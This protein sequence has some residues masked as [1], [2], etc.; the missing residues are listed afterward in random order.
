VLSTAKLSLVPSWCMRT[1][2]HSAGLLER[3]PAAIGC[4]DGS[5]KLFE[6]LLSRGDGLGGLLIECRLGHRLMQIG[7]FCLQLLN[8]LR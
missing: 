3:L 4:S 8:L 7:Q 2:I 1:A 6:L 5:L